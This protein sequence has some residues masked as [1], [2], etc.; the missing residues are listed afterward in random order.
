MCWSFKVSL[1]TFLLA[2]FAASYLWVRNKPNDR[3]FSIYIF[4]VGLIQGVEALG[5]YSI[6]TNNTNMNYVAGFLTEF[7]IF[8]QIIFLHFYLYLTSQNNMYL[9]IS[10]LAFG[11]WIYEIQKRKI[12]FVDVNCM[13]YC[14]MRWSWISNNHSIIRIIYLIFLAYPLIYFIKD[15]R[16]KIVLTF[17]I[18]TYLY[19]VYTYSQTNTWGSFWCWTV[20]LS[21]PFLLY[22]S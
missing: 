4:V 2:I 16:S 21:I 14:H 18:I 22:F 17:G 11:L 7:V 8:F 6:D 10:L 19:S 12:Y 3:F 20:N 5:W 13:Q 15:I 9:C 1:F